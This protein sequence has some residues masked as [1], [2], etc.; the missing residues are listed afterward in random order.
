MMLLDRIDASHLYSL[1]VLLEERHVTRAARRLGI[2]QSSMS[3]RLQRLRA[4]LGD[5]LLARAGG[6]LLPTPRAEALAPRLAEALRA[7]EAAVTPEAAFDP[8]ACTQ[9]LTLMMPDLLAPVL[10]HVLTAVGRAAPGMSLRVRPVSAELP[11]LLAAGPL[12]LA[13]AP[14][15]FVGGHTRS[16]LLGELRFAVAGRR[17]HPA[18]RPRLT[19]A[20]WLAH[21]HVVVHIGNERANAV[22]DAL[23][24][25]GLRRR[26]A[27][28]VPSFL[29]GLQVVA[30]S[31]LLMNVPVPL[32][33]E[34]ASALGLEVHPAP[35]A[36]PRVRFAM[37]WHERFQHDAAHR[38]ARDTVFAA[39]RPLLHERP[40][41]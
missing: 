5:P 26:V 6:G 7:L 30:R 32:V 2:T 8:A 23:T 13:L 37:L 9:T 11:H 31:D 20:R 14:A 33:N 28:E 21:G 39:V 3:H 25:R 34:A 19:V 18:L 15:H 35:L 40:R 22:A 1:H 12:S 17:G 29:A 27:L 4:A 10:P 41:G 36:L 24:R 16:R 38:W